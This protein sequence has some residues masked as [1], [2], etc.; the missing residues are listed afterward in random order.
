[1]NK[2]CKVFG[3]EKLKPLQKNI[4][5]AVTIEKSDVL[6]ILATGYGKSTCYQLPFLIFERQKCIIVICPLLSLMEDQVTKLDELEIEAIA[7][8]SNMSTK[9]KERAKCAILMGENK[10]I[11]MSPEFC[12]SQCDFLTQL[13]DED[14]IGLIAIDESHCVS[15]WGND[16]RPDYKNL[17]CLREWLPET[18]ILALTATA[19]VKVRE[20]IAESLNLGEYYEFVSSFNRENLLIECKPK[21]VN[22]MDDLKQLVKEYKTRQTI[23]Y[24]RTRDSTE[25]LANILTQLKVKVAIYH[26][27]LSIA[28]K[29]SAFKSF[30]DKTIHW[31][32][33]TVALGMGI[34]QNVDLVVHYGSPGDLDTYY[35]E[36]GRAGRHGGEARCTMFYGKADMRINRILL[37]NIQDVEY[38]KHRDGQI[39]IME[40]FIRTN[41]CRRKILLNY[42]GESFSGPCDKCDNCLRNVQTV[43]EVNE[44]QRALQ[45]PMFIFRA[46]L[47]RSVIKSG[48]SKIIDILLGKG[49][50]KTKE[51]RKSPFYGIGKRYNDKM[52][53]CIHDLC[54]LNGYTEETTIS[55]GFGTIISYTDKMTS[56]YKEILP[57]LKEHKIT[58]LDYDNFM[59]YGHCIY[60]QFNVTSNV[61]IMKCDS[62]RNTTML[63]DLITEQME[64]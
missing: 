23:V 45:Y 54:L 43:E 63:E 59:S 17:S 28:S 15:S 50:N 7:L 26:G 36:I 61:V 12:V 37:K 4:I 27:G 60:E 16:F 38:K 32:V 18:P 31:I 34:D 56:W 25:H 53:R 41:E 8:N 20:D 64:I 51:Y 62:K 21:S 57:I 30:T 29:E 47:I 48:I 2:L 11:Y 22:P 40:M 5:N 19:T 3:Y 42:F 49:G 9:D 1:M 55:N 13:Y 10:I 52:W 39:K 24:V 44:T 46:F 14:R 6:A 35:Q 33:A 58:S